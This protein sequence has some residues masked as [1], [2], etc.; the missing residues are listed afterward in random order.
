MSERERDVERKQ[1]LLWIL[2]R[3]HADTSHSPRAPA[4]RRPCQPGSAPPRSQRPT[5]PGRTGRGWSGSCL[6]VARS[7]KLQ[8]HLSNF[9][10]VS[11]LCWHNCP[12]PGATPPS[13]PLAKL[14]RA[15]SQPPKSSSGITAPCPAPT[16]L[17]SRP[18]GTTVPLKMTGSCGTSDRCDLRSRRPMCPVSICS[19]H[20]R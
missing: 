14:P 8:C 2:S 5:T 9:Q 10:Q 12:V 20:S 16:P 3:E 17:P 11:A 19:T 18:L 6:R 7:A 15:R 4:Q 1:G 13:L